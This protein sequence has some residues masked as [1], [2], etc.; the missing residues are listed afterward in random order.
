MSQD[1]R[2]KMRHQDS[3]TH[4]PDMS[5]TVRRVE[6]HLHQLPLQDDASSD[7]NLFSDEDQ[8]ASHRRRTLKSCIVMMGAPI[9]IKRI[10]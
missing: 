10:T 5:E 9:V 6:Q 1:A 3:P 8:T 2:R 7:E 4:Q